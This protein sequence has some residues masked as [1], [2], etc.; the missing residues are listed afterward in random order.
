VVFKENS[1]DPCLFSKFTKSGIV[2]VG[3]NVD[4]FMVIGC[5]EDIGEVIKGL[6]GYGFG[7]KIE[8]FL[9]NYLS[10]K[11]TMNWEK[12]EVLVMQPH[13]LK[14]LED[15]FGEEVNNLRNYATPGTPRFK[16]VKSSDMVET[17]DMDWQSRYRSG[18]EMLLYLIKYS[19]PDIA[20]VVRE[21]S[22]C[23]EEQIWLPTRRCYG[24]L[25]LF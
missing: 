2:L 11:I 21:I 12:L 1:V 22:K 4:Y 13:L 20:N 14:G 25:S 15:K 23:M 18:V 5:D 7:L 19:R 24:S 6:K 9:T 10:F 16:V 17:I 3:I 8:D